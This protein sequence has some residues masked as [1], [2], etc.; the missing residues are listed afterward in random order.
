MATNTDN[1]IQT[2]PTN[3]SGASKDRNTTGILGKDDFLK[4]LVAQLKHQDPMAPTADQEWIGQMAQ[5]SQLEQASNT[6]QDTSRIANQLGHAGALGLI[7]RT[8]SYLDADGNVLTGVVEQVDMAGDGKASLTI[9]GQAGIDAAE[10][11][12]VR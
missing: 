3:F 1:T 9:D 4:L 12:Q 5:F 7:G 8:V 10:V 6:A 11:T 2:T